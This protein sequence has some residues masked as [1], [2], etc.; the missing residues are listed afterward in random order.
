MTPKLEFVPDD[1]VIGTV[2]LL[3]GL[4]PKGTVGRIRDPG[5]S[6]D[7]FY[8]IWKCKYET[9]GFYCST[10]WLGLVLN[11]ELVCK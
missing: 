5:P 3:A 9:L 10:E 4:I 2:D 11:E 8:T 7:R 1:V 6:P